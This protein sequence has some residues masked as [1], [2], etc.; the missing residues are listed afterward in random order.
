MK[1]RH[2]L[3]RSPIADHQTA[4]NDGDAAIESLGE[5]VTSTKNV[6]GSHS[7]ATLS[8]TTLSDG[9]LFG[10]K[11]CFPDNSQELV[12]NHLLEFD[13]V[14]NRR[15]IPSQTGIISNRIIDA[16]KSPMDESPEK[17]SDLDLS[18]EQLALLQLHLT[19]GLGPRIATALLQRFGTASAVL[20]QP[21]NRL[22]TVRRVSLD[23]A[24]RIIADRQL[25][26]ARREWTQLKAAQIRL[27]FQ[28][29]DGFP[30]QLS[31]LP[32]SPLLLY[33]RG[34]YLAAD[35]RAIAIV[36]SRNCST[37]G[38]RMADRLARELC[39]RGYTIVSGLARGIDG[40]AHEGA[41]DAGGRTIAVVAS[42]LNDIYP[43]QHV[44]LADRVCDRGTVLSESPLN[45]KPRTGAFPQR[46]RLISG[47]SQ[48]VI[49]VE[50]THRSGT[51]H[52]VRHAIDQGREVLAVPGRVDS[53]T[54]E[55]CLTLISEGAAI[56]RNA[57]DVIAALGECTVAQLDRHATRV[58]PEA[59]PAQPVPT[60]TEAE[61]R[62]FQSLPEGPIQIDEIL[63]AIPSEA[64]QTLSVLTMLEMKQVIERSP[65]GVIEKLMQIG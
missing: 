54:S 31:L 64:S 37:Y 53:P 46:N 16:G 1:A 45:R 10:G 7:T 63:R 40:A 14:C 19:F 12:P 57:D 34:Q 59:A 20:R 58:T 33:S 62:L 50:A 41:L 23:L 25:T 29:D 38:R 21:V 42:P 11:P 6:E 48:A 49:V 2:S 8:P 55:A 44:Q 47:L 3:G 26:R 27:M 60:L 61:R 51:L 30:E 22:R 32:D 43:A 13:G 65:G 35:Q 24:R 4:D 18:Y 36:G 56:A 5:C 28:G 9:V 15:W 39:S 17:G 52:T